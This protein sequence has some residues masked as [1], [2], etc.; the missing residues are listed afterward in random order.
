MDRKGFYKIPG[1][2][3]SDY[4]RTINKNYKQT[5]QLL[6]RKVGCITWEILFT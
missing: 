5:K 4:C 1:V 6:L 3:P 2:P